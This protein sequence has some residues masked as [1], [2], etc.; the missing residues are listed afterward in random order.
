MNGNE[1][2]NK[3][4]WKCN[5]NAD[6]DTIRIR[7][8]FHFSLEYSFPLKFKR[9]K[10]M[11]KNN[12]KFD[13]YNKSGR[14]DTHF[15]SCIQH[16][17]KNPNDPLYI[18]IFFFNNFIILWISKCITFFLYALKY[19]LSCASRWKLVESSHPFYRYYSLILVSLFKFDLNEMSFCQLFY[20]P[21]HL[22]IVTFHLINQCVE[23]Y[24]CRR[25]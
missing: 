2:E 8:L 11:K 4:I 10:A 20:S 15:Y 14:K 21:L 12:K 7:K 18:S 22:V 19:A 9:K 1:R 3:M 16:W 5:R 13:I 17:Y 24:T 23:I 6:A 25:F